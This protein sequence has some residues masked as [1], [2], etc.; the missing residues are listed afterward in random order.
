MAMR[1]EDIRERGRPESSGTWR[2]RPCHEILHS[3]AD[4]R[5]R[6]NFVWPLGLICASSALT[7]GFYLQGKLPFDGSSLE[8]SIL[9]FLLVSL[10]VFLFSLNSYSIALSHGSF[11]SISGEAGTGK[12]GG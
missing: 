9:W 2:T 4:R 10:F 6:R 12:G 11:S 8:H 5:R 7:K 3:E 1:E